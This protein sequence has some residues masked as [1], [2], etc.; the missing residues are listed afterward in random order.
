MWKHR[1]TLFHRHT[2]AAVLIGLL[3]SAF[4]LPVPLGADKKKATPPPVNP[5]DQRITAYFDISKIMWPS[6]PEIARIRFVDLFTGEKI[7]RSK[8]EPKKKKKSWMD[9][10]AGTTPTD[11]IKIDSLP[12]QLIRTYGLAVDSKGKIYA[13]DQAV[14]AV[15]IFDLEHK[16]QVELIGNGKQANFAEIVG[17]A[18]DDNDRLF[19]TDAKMRHVLVFNAKHEQEAMFG[20]D[21]LVRPGGIAIDAENRFVYVVDAGNDCV[22]VFDADTFKLLRHIGK[23]SK[24]HEQ[25]DPGTFSLPTA[26]ALDD[27]GNVYVT[28]TFNSRIEIF[29]ADGNFISMFGK[30]GDGPADLGRPKSIA[31]DR[32]G[33][34]WV[35]DAFQ[36]RVKVFNQQGRLLIYFGEQGYFP[37]QF[38]GPWGIAI[39]KWNRVMVSETYPGRVQVFRYIT[40]AEAAAEKAKRESEENQKPSRTPTPA[41]KTST[42]PAPMANATGKPPGN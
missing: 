40:D 33:H 28:D 3:A 6:P 19:V 8:F 24:K 7:D 15:F 29:D 26:V 31:I 42:E 30:I 9:R 5:G 17:L 14:G 25:T 35:I 38:M 20:G 1:P 2:W 34:I 36:N 37:G 23:P 11:Q 21:V 13:A 10:M 12:F 22:Q 16:D 32:D 18:M 41:P 4:V 27:D 39:D